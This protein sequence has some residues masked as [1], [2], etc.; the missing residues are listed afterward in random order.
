M[1]SKWPNSAAF[2]YPVVAW[3]IP[4]KIKQ[5]VEL[6][7]RVRMFVIS[8]LFGP[9]LGHPIT[10]FLYLVDPDGTLNN[11]ANGNIIV[12]LVVNSNFGK[13]IYRSSAERALRV[14][15]RVRF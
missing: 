11:G 1:L 8:H 15:M 10:L 13:P 4:T 14:G 2:V 5:D 6:V 9:F 12:P 7:Q 3:F